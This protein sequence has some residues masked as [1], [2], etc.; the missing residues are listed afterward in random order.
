MVAEGSKSGDFLK[1][2]FGT[3]GF[4]SLLNNL[5]LVEWKGLKR[6]AST[7][8]QDLPPIFNSGWI[9]LSSLLFHFKQGINNNRLYD[10]AVSWPIA[11][12]GHSHWRCG[13]HCVYM[14]RSVQAMGETLFPRMG[15][16]MAQRVC[17]YD[18]SVCVSWTF[19]L[20]P[21]STH[22]WVGTQAF[23]P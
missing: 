23:L 19:G 9:C 14:I 15:T 10:D 1:A 20:D 22:S 6:G 12:K 13:F 2:V 7:E 5:E 3:F 21:E 8:Y 17:M 11:I 4:F 16:E 18:K